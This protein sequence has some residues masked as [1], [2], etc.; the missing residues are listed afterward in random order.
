MKTKAVFIIVL[1]SILLISCGSGKTNNSQE[2]SNV[3]VLRS[4]NATPDAVKNPVIISKVTHDVDGLETIY[5][6]NI[7][8]EKQ[9]INGY[10][11]Y[12][13]KTDEHINILDIKLDRGASYKVYNGPRAMEQKDGL[14]WLDHAILQQTGDDVILLNHAGRLIWD[15]TYSK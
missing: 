6:T 2:S 14:A 11:L 8:N 1:V 12:I 3:E 7:S 13:M 9:D 5:I 15:F 4:F 10:S